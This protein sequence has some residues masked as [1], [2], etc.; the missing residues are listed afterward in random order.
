MRPL[1]V[2]V[3]DDNADAADS[4]SWVLRLL[5][6]V[7]QVAYDGPS[8]VGLAPAFR[9]DVVLCD[10]G[11]PGDCDGYEVGRRLRGLGAVLVAVTGYGGEEYRR[12]ADEAGFHAYFVRP[13]DPDQLG[14]VLAAQAGPRGTTPAASVVGRAP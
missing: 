6:H 12:R 9:P 2:L 7:T 14:R 3:V 13:L 4:L 5:G 1:R 11:L 10:L 8:A